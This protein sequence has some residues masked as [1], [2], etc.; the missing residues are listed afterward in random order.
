MPAKEWSRQY[1]G[2]LMLAAG[3]AAPSPANTANT[4]KAWKPIRKEDRNGNGVMDDLES[5]LRD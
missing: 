2:L 1:N 4:A 5:R 3:W